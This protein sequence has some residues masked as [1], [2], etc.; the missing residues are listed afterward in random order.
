MSFSKFKDLFWII[1]PAILL[2]AGAFWGTYQFVEPAPPTSMTISTGGIKGAYYDFGNQYAAIL[3]KSGIELTVEPSAGSLD[4]IER[5]K[6]KTAKVDLAL[7][8]GGISNAKLSPELMS[9][10]RIF[11][12]PLWVFYRKE[13]SIEKLTDLKGKRIT[14][15]AKNSGTGHLALSLLAANAISNENA[16]LIQMGSQSAIDALE[17]GEIDAIFLV[18]APHSLMIDKLLHNTELKVMNFKRAEAYTRNFSYLSKIVLPQ[19]AVDFVKN[20]PNEDISL[21]ATSAALVAQKKLHPALAGLLIEAL[22]DVHSKGN[23]FQ[24]NGEFPQSFDPEYPVTDDTV[25]SYSQGIPFLQRYLPFWLA[26]FLQRTFLLLLPIATV[27][28]PVV[29]LAPILYHWRV[30]QRIL[31]W[32]VQ[33]KNLEQDITPD[34]DA[35][36]IK[37]HQ[38]ELERIET[39]VQQIPVPTEFADQFYHLRGAVGLVRKRLAHERGLKSN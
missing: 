12:E 26:S 27:L 25:R 24:T 15:G 4:N 36:K 14:I 21:V 17:N 22:K 32:Y 11:L 10:G 13:L 1:V 16:T 19:G 34:A 5:L 3:K 29:K 20:I 37:Q 39:A 23:M 18:L 28:F 30:R 33:L 8:Q 7:I 35:E 6:A 2:I 38:N 31:H 9:L